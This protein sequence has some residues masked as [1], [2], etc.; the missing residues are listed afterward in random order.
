MICPHCHK[1]VLDDALRAAEFVQLPTRVVATRLGRTAVGIT[2]H[3]GFTSYENG[4]VVGAA[5]S[6][7]LRSRI[8]RQDNPIGFAVDLR[9]IPP[10]VLT[11]TFWAGVI[12]RLQTNK[13]LQP[14]KEHVAFFADHD[15]QAETGRRHL[16][17][18]ELVEEGAR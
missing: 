15:F 8:E 2:A 16:Q 12:S 9:G 6:G 1:D 13:L 5:I 11:S 18:A 14:A 7:R 10:S 17:E 3:T 4:E